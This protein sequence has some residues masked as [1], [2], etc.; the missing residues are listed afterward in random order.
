MLPDDNG[1]SLNDVLPALG[2]NPSRI[3]SDR[4]QDACD[5]P[6]NANVYEGSAQY[7]DRRQAC[8]PFHQVDDSA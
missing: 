6:T 4:D 8:R 1:V 5:C 2:S 3:R 7:L